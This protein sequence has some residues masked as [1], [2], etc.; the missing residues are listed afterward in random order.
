MSERCYLCGCEN[1][2][3]RDHIPP[4]GFFPPPRPSDLITVPCCAACNA[5]FSIEDEYFR[6]VL[7][8][9]VGRSPA[10]DKIWEDRVVPRSLKR[11]PADVNAIL[12]S[13]KDAVIQTETGPLEAVSFEI[14]PERAERYVIRLTKGLLTHYYPSYDYSSCSFDVRF[15]SPTSANLELLAEYRDMLHFEEKGD[16][17]FRYRFGLTD[18]KESGLWMLTFYDAVLILVFHRPDKRGQ[19][20][21]VD[22]AAFE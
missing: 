10:G 16:R 12:R 13:I 7:S 1:A 3:T 15:V 20:S 14:D 2:T 5:A 11:L 9:L 4:R 6:L 8:S 19:A 21:D 17:V 22:V 18:T